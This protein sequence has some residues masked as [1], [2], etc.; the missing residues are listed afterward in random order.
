MAKVAEGAGSEGEDGRSAGRDDAR[1]ERKH[2]R[3]PAYSLVIA[4][5]TCLRRFLR[6]RRK[7]LND[8]HR[9]TAVRTGNKPIL[10]QAILV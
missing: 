8:L 1:K 9:S 6:S 3:R 7:G 2:R 10:R 5:A 4:F